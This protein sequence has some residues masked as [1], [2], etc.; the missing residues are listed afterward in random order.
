MAI[1]GPDRQQ[2][3][4]FID[5]DRD[6]LMDILGADTSYAN[7]QQSFKYNAD[8]SYTAFGGR[9]WRVGPD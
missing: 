7:G 4:S 9:L 6:G 1:S 8:G 3:S 2:Q 5:F